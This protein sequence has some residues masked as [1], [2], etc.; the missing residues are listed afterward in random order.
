MRGSVV[1]ISVSRG[2]LPK[3]PVPEAYLTSLG[4][5]GDAA[6]H[7]GIHGGPLKAVLLMASETVDSLIARGYPLLYGAA[8]E[9][10][11]TRGIDPRQM[12]QGQ[13]YQLGQAMIE[14][15]SIRV[16]CSTL[17]R[18]GAALKREI[19][20]KSVGE[21]DVTSHLWGASGFYAAVV[22]PGVI[23]AHDIIWLVD[24]AV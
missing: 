6:A 3:R 9:N 16:P 17:D 8:G 14:L 13:R 5:E 1:Q 2:G 19:W 20:D 10:L 7:P 4:F 21:G 24:A 22:Q 18:Y 12:R 23:R 11:T 15:T